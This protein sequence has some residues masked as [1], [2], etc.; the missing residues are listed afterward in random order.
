[1]QKSGI[2]TNRHPLLLVSFVRLLTNSSFCLVAFS[3][4]HMNSLPPLLS[5][6]DVADYLGVSRQTVY[7]YIYHEGLPSITVGGIRRIHPES[8]KKWLLAREKT[9]GQKTRP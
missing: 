3:H 9:L 7:T 2:V 1:M 4:M 8:L 5:V 6:S